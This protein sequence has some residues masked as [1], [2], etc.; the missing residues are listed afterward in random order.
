MVPNFGW[1][2]REER[3]GDLGIDVWTARDLGDS[4]GLGGMLQ[5]ALALQVV[6]R[7]RRGH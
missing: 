4:S 6:E 1:Q 2:D 5:G 3:R 7:G